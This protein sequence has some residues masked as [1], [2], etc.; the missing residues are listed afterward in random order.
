M[1]NIYVLVHWLVL[2]RFKNILKKGKNKSSFCRL[3][4]YGWG[5]TDETYQGVFSRL[6]TSVS[7]FNVIP[8][9]HA[10]IF[11]AIESPPTP[12]EETRISN[13]YRVQDFLIS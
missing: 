10:E 5:W 7:C 3:I 11:T 13:L 9:I 1:I 2:R 6:N 8:I 4:E 12:N